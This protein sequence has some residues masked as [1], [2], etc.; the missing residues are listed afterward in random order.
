M[1]RNIG[2]I[3]VVVLFVL[4]YSFCVWAETINVDEVTFGE[5]EGYGAIYGAEY[6][7]DNTSKWLTI[8]PGEAGVRIIDK[9]NNDLFMVDKYG[10]IYMN[11]TVFVNGEELSSTKNGDFTPQNGFMYLLI[12]ISLGMNVFLLTKR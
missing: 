10:G 8:K 1:K 12:V 2:F 6:S 7:S 3:S 11:G 5:K 4:L 9:D